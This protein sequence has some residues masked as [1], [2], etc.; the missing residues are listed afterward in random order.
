MVAIL[1]KATGTVQS[2]G[3]YI[4]I[5]GHYSAAIQEEGGHV[6]YVF[7]KG[8]YGAFLSALLQK[9]D[10]IWA[11]YTTIPGKGGYLPDH[12]GKKLGFLLPEPLDKAERIRHA[13]FEIQR[14]LDRAELEANEARLFSDAND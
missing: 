5:C 1:K 6:I 8:A 7:F 4:G 9:G 2:K 10:K 3:H 13:E 11:T 14:I 12:I